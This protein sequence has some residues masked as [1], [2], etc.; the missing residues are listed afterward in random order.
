MALRAQWRLGSD[1]AQELLEV[2]RI[3]GGL[4][5]RPHRR[6]IPVDLPDRALV[7]SHVRPLNEL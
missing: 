3:E 4:G 5:E 1:A 7:R 2:I 6:Q